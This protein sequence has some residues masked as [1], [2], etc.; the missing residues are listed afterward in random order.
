[1]NIKRLASAA[2]ITA[3]VGLSTL[4]F[5]IGQVNAAPMPNPPSPTQTGT[6]PIPGSVHEPS[7]P[8]SGAQPHSGGGG[9]HSG[10]GSMTQT[11]KTP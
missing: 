4:M 11:T 8:N 6:P 10:G 3:A 5:G 7:A 1:M 9:P 2:A